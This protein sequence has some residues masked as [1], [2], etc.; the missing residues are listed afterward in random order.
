MS[1]IVFGQLSAVCSLVDGITDDC[2]RQRDVSGCLLGEYPR[3]QRQRVFLFRFW[4][5]RRRGDRREGY[6][7][8][9]GHN[10]VNNGLDHVT[11][12]ELMNTG[13]NDDIA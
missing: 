1:L 8:I 6:F 5:V 10:G 7:S 4:F 13:C 12:T 11:L 2:V 3:K 9:T